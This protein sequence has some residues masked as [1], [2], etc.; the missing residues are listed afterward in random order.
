MSV[1]YRFHFL[2]LCIFCHKS[3]KTYLSLVTFFSY[4]PEPTATLLMFLLAL[5]GLCKC[6]F[7][8]LYITMLPLE[9]LLV[10]MSILHCFAFYVVFN[11]NCINVSTYAKIY[12]WTSCFYKIAYHFR[13]VS[14]ISPSDQVTWSSVVNEFAIT[15]YSFCLLRNIVWNTQEKTIVVSIN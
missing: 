13:F 14:V 2:A 7:V 15:A 4:T 8:F 6:E 3:G 10:S 11:V 5:L 9:N 12:L 1:S